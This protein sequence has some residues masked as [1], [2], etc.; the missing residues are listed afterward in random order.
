MVY[1]NEKIFRIV[2]LIYRIKVPAKGYSKMKFL[3]TFT[4][5]ITI[6]NLKHGTC[7]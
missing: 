6:K 7:Q 4:Q 3:K 2:G 1:V 5:T